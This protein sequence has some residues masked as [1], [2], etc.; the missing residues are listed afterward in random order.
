MT[1]FG[2]IEIETIQT[3]LTKEFYKN[4]KYENFE[5]LPAFW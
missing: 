3:K 1:Y 2:K 5:I 4:A